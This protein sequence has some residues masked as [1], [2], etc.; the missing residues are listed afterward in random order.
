MILPLSI[1]VI[2]KFILIRCIGTYV[3][4][5]YESIINFNTSM[6]YQV[7]LL[8]ITVGIAFSAYSCPKYK[9]GIDSLYP[10]PAD[11][12]VCSKRVINGAE[13]TYQLKICSNSASQVCG[14]NFQNETSSCMDNVTSVRGLLPG[15]PC[16]YSENC[17]SNLCTTGFCVGADFGYNCVADVQCRAGA[18]CSPAGKCEALAKE[19][20]V[21]GEGIAKCMNHLT[22]NVGTCVPIGS[23][24]LNA[25]ANDAMACKSMYVA[26]DGQG[27]QR[28][29]S[30]PTLIGFAGKMVECAVGSMCKYSLGTPDTELQLPCRCGAN[31]SGKAYCHPGEGN[32][33]TDVKA[34]RLYQY[35]SVLVHQ[36]RSNSL[37][38]PVPHRD[39]LVL[40]APTDG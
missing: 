17:A 12:E 13:T 1:Y 34:V 31:P 22:C 9:C 27:V 2:L 15:D 19:G 30:A 29:A 8:A 6:R 16:V 37:Q 40:H 39:P 25:V 11:G 32:M 20:S 28:C 24:D 21:C 26:V 4:G 5:L 14:F 23:M 33:Q 18:F 36:I 10:L 7:L 35:N 3:D 38:Q